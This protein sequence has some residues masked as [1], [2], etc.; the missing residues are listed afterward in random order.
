MWK[1]F[2]SFKRGEKNFVAIENEADA[3]TNYGELNSSLG[4]Y[5]V[6][7]HAGSECQWIKPTLCL[8]L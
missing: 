3:L 5:E 7:E 2:S 1:R 6:V 8:M 4:V